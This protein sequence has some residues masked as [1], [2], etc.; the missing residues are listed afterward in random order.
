MSATDSNESYS[1]SDFESYQSESS[2]SENE[3]PLD[4]DD[5][6]DQY[7]LPEVEVEERLNESIFK[8]K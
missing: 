3:F 1:G 6:D 2:A 4:E 5:V 8:K 7:K